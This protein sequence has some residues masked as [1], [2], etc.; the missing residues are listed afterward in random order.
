MHFRMAIVSEENQQKIVEAIITKMMSPVLLTNYSGIMNAVSGTFETNMN[1]DEITDLI[2]MQLNDMSS[3]TFEQ[4]SVDGTNS[5]AV[6]F[7]SGGQ[8]LY[9]MEPNR[10]TVDEAVRKINEVLSGK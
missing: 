10:A 8:L 9:V 3:W 4:Q 2:Q 6:T 7:G 1:S 5:S